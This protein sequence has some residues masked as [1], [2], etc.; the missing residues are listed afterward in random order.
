MP[1]HS[2]DVR[3]GLRFNPSEIIFHI[4]GHKLGRDYHRMVRG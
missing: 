2:L 3:F 4:R 1:F